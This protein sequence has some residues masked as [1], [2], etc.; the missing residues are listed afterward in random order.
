ML[1]YLEM[2]RLDL[3]TI[4]FLHFVVLLYFHPSP[5]I[6]HTNRDCHCF[7]Y[8]AGGCRLY[9]FGILSDLPCDIRFIRTH[10][11]GCDHLPAHHR[12]N[13]GPTGERVLQSFEGRRGTC[14]QRR[15]QAKE[16]LKSNS[17]INYILKAKLISII[18]NV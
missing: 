18:P 13:Q 6:H 14:C 10:L 3:F 12:R 9:L 16:G 1:R 8:L 11:C 7:L 17:K 5:Q 15:N 2:I 4:I